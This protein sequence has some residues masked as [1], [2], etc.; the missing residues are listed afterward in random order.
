MEAILKKQ[1]KNIVN[2]IFEL[3]KALS[4]EEQKAIK[5]VIDGFKI[6]KVVEEGK[7]VS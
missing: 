4:P 2:E 3:I 6:A 5:Y 1:D 7:E